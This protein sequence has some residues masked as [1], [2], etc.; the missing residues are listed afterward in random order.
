VHDQLRFQH[1]HSNAERLI[2]HACCCDLR[3]P[4]NYG[5]MIYQRKGV[6]TVIAKKSDDCDP[7]YGDPRDELKFR[8]AD[9]EWYG[10]AYEQLYIQK[11]KMDEQL[12]ALAAKLTP[13]QTT[14]H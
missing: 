11:L 9:L 8:H 10:E 5:Q 13:K 12:K 4:I 1:R 7:V 3:Q 2:K 6:C 14:V